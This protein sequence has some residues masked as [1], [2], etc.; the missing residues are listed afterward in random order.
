M[1]IAAV[2]ESFP[3]IGGCTVPRG[4]AILVAE[5]VSKRYDTSLR[6]LRP[7]GSFKKL[8]TPKASPYRLWMHRLWGSSW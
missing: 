2:R 5:R 4:E 8:S 6:R 1:K 7:V 3:Q